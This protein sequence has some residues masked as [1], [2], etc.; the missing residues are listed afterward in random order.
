MKT[1]KNLRSAFSASGEGSLLKVRRRY[2]GTASDQAGVEPVPVGTVASREVPAA[3]AAG[4]AA[5]GVAL[6]PRILNITASQVGHLPFTALRPFFITSSTASEIGFFA[7]HLTQY[8]SSMVAVRRFV[9]R[10]PGF[11][12]LV[13]TGIPS[14]SDPGPTRATDRFRPFP[15]HHARSIERR[16]QRNSNM[17]PSWG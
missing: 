14:Q 10:P 12:D 16:C 15:D 13:A 5:E 8:P 7:L 1:P 4:P 2:P 11:L 9:E 17:L 6:P 3:S